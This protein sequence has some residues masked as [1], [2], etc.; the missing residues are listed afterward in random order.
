MRAVFGISSPTRTPGKEVAMEPNGPRI[1]AGALGLGSQVS[2]CGGPP[3]IHK[4]M[5]AFALPKH[6]PG[7]VAAGV[8]CNRARERPNALR[9]PM[10]NS[11]RRLNIGRTSSSDGLA[12]GL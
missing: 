11:S 7:E 5:H 4:T 10:R 9:P 6:R 12:G 8:A 3:D 2:C 1:S